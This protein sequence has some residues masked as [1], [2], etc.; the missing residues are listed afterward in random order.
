[1]THRWQVIGMV[2]VSLAASGCSFVP[3]PSIPSSS[4]VSDSTRA[5]P[6]VSV[7][8]IQQSFRRRTNPGND[9][10]TYEPCD[11]LSVQAAK[12]L[13][14]D[15]SSIKDTAV[16][17]G[18][19][20]RGCFWR[21]S[22]PESRNL[23]LTQSVSNSPSPTAYKSKQRTNTWRADMTIESR[24]ISVFET[25]TNTCGTYVQVE[26]A[27]VITVAQ[28]TSTLS[29]PIDEICDRA[30]AFTRATIDKMPR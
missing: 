28:F 30:I 11:A 25:S 8:G 22:P 23:F 12:S 7:S 24:A 21:Y 4:V 27:G 19:T 5:D 15:P 26:R 6:T 16:V 18:Q 2:T 17:D 3:A 20:A 1:M 9:G 10:S 29:P 14:I 13:G